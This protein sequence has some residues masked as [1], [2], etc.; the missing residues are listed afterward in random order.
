MG[1]FVFG[2]LAVAIVGGGGDDVIV[3]EFGNR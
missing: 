2:V 3:A 1:V